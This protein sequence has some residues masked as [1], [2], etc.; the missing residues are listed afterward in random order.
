MSCCSSCR[1]APSP[2][3]CVPS[4]ETSSGCAF[5]LVPFSLLSVLAN[6]P[7]AVAALLSE[8]GTAASHKLHPATRSSFQLWRLWGLREKCRS[9]GAGRELGR[10]LDKICQRLWQGRERQENIVE[11]AGEL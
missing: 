5:G 11:K 8:D 2:W 4:A 3:L 6:I 9:L 7:S 10:E 1:A